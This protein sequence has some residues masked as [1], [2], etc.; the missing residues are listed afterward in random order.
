[1]TDKRRRI[2]NVSALICFFFL[3]STS[4]QP[5]PE[6]LYSV[7]EIQNI[8]SFTWANQHLTRFPRSSM[9]LVPSGYDNQKVVQLSRRIFT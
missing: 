5:A 1:M 4:L 6:A 2:S 8:A 9:G 3:Q 7:F